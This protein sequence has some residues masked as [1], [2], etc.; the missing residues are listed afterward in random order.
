VVT[1]CST[2]FNIQKLYT[3][4]KECTYVFRIIFI[5]KEVNPICAVKQLLFLMGRTE[6]CAVP[7]EV[8]NIIYTNFRLQNATN[9]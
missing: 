7:I 6:L 3:F 1:I 4:P 8:R 9:N 2:Y 5:V